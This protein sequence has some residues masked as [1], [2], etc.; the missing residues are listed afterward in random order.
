MKGIKGI[1]VAFC[2]SLSIMIAIGYYTYI[3]TRDYER[4][5][6]WVDHTQQ[7]IAQ[8]RILLLDVQD[9]ESAA[10]G[11]VITGKE[12]SLKR[13]EVGLKNI[14]HNYLDLKHL[15]R[16]NPNQLVLLDTIYKTV[17]LKIG[18]MKKVVSVRQQRGHLFAQELVSTEVGEDLMIKVKAL[19]YKFISNEDKLLLERRIAS[20][21]HFSYVVA[22]IIVSIFLIL[23]IVMITLYSFIKDYNRRILSEKQLKESES[24]LQKFADSLPIGVYIVNP[25]GMPVYANGKFKEILGKGMIKDLSPEDFPDVF[26]LYIAGTEDL[27]PADQRPLNRVLRGE[28][29][30]CVENM[31]VLKGGIRVP[32]RINATSVT[33]AEGKIDYAIAVFEDITDIKAAEH[34]LI[35]A[36]KAADESVIIKE[37]FLAN[38]SHEIRTPMNAIMGFTDLLLKKDLQ[39]KDRDYVQIIKTSGENLLRIINDIL[40]V[41]KINS[42]MMSFEE[43]PISIR[44]I[45]T[46]LNVMLAQRAKEK[47]LKLSFEHTNDIPQILLGDPTR[48][49]QIILNLVGNAIKFTKEGGV[50]VFAKVLE[51]DE[52]TCRIEFSVKDTGIGIAPEKLQHI[53]ERFTQAESSIT[54]TYGGTG[55]G[56]NIAKLLAELQGGGMTVESI[57]GMGSVFTVT[58]P[59]KKADK[60]VIFSKPK[61]AEF[62]IRELSRFKILI[63]EDNPINIKF[64]SS[65]LSENKIS[66]DIAEN[67]QLAVEKLKEN[68]YDIVIMDIEMPEMNGYEATAAIRNEL[69]LDIPI[70][71]MTANAMVG[72]KEKCLHLGMNDYISKPI[73]AD[74]LFE[75]MFDALKI[76]KEKITIPDHKIINLD[77][78][79]ESMGGNH[80]VISDIIDMFIKQVP[81]DL[82]ILNEA[83]DK[84]DFL[85]IKQFSHRMKSTVSVMGISVIEKILR[86]MEDLGAS[87]SGIEE[88]KSL[89][90]QLNRIFQTAVAEAELEKLNYVDLEQLN[91]QTTPQ[92]II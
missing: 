14:D 86:E 28:K 79:V 50:D 92:V 46:S 20:R 23:A 73:A 35:Q 61:H 82:I 62:N 60:T 36:K 91:T 63:V 6:S 19:S 38:M 18:F 90:L 40:D 16:N 32:L 76:G 41:S 8:T 3:T 15:I 59:F 4:S 49:T 57:A 9:I 48:L 34:A 12:K 39:V 70:I 24:R 17:Q 84:S 74:I 42:G 52:K 25:D 69:K 30:I 11:F 51:E 77:F 65:L 21:Q 53:F 33:N 67:G 37:T 75:K 72:E 89:A 31:E 56:L 13:Y 44:E 43:H 2:V 87:E 83:V 66:A 68:D 10:R 7:I 54:R 81:V 47:K 71:A 85:T 45:F 58:L 64:V 26:R 29:D 27:F 78:L 5:L 1:L 80:E 88:I 22:M 55:L